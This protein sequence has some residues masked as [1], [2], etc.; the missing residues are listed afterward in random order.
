[1]P[2][3]PIATSS[4]YYAVGTTKY[5]Y[6]L[7]VAN[8]AAPTRAEINAGTDLSPEIAEVSGFMVKSE[9]IP[10]K[11]IDNRFVSK[12][13]GDINAEDSALKFYASSDSVDVRAL[14][15]RDTIGYVLR[16]DGGD[17]AGR[18]MDVFPIKVAAL[19]KDMGTG[20]NAAT[21]EVQFT[22]TDPPQEN[23]VIP[24]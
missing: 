7:T 11:D 9:Q 17:V 22:I 3:T 16:M 4:R 24:A 2:A 23:L 15:P 20:T 12:I 5:I 10:T 13:P 21:I 1:M 18:K 6:A 8:P 14:L 19:S